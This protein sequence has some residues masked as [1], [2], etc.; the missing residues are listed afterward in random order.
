MKSLRGSPLDDGSFGPGME[1]NMTT[2]FPAG[3]GDGKLAA[4][5]SVFLDAI[6][7][8]SR[9]PFANCSS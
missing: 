5:A 2:E 9:P 4:G 1:Q 8:L 3:D 6:E 7:T